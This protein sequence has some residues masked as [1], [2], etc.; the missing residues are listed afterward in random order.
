M[1]R[2]PTFSPAVPT[3]TPPLNFI[4]PAA[5]HSPP[6]P[7]SLASP[8][9][10]DLAGRRPS[11]DPL[12]PSRSNSRQLDGAVGGSYPYA[13]RRA[14]QYGDGWYALTG[15]KYGDEFDSFRSFRICSPTPGVIGPR[16]Q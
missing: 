10:R 6:G 16:A 12:R 13:A 7:R 9:R 15:T 11:S 2:S 8:W 3:K 4:P 5:R 1:I 14:V